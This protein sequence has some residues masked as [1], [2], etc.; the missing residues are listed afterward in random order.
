MDPFPLA[1]ISQLNTVQNKAA[2]LLKTHAPALNKSSLHLQHS[3]AA[4][5]TVSK[6]H[7]SYSPKRLPL[8][9]PKRDL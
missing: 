6:M 8:H 7:F 3:A 2:C 9:L 5:S 4:V 1:W